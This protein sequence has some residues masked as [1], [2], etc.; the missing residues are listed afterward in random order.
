MSGRADDF[1]DQMAEMSAR[2]DGAKMSLAIEMLPALNEFTKRIVEA[3]NEAGKLHAVLVSARNHAGAFMF[4]DE[5][6]E[7]QKKIKNLREELEGLRS[8][9]ALSKNVPFAGVA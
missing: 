8:D 4:S 2:I 7:P 1:N 9:L 6:A 5:F 3:Y